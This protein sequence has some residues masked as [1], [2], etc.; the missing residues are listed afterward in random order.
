MANQRSNKKNANTSKA[1][2]S[3]QTNIGRTSGSQNPEIEKADARFDISN[4]DRQEGNLLHGE[5]GGGMK[6]E[7]DRT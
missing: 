2:G 7:D 3:K 6:C 5:C 4:V 1:N